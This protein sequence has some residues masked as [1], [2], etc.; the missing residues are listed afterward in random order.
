MQD[1]YFSDEELVAYLDGEEDFAPVK[2]IEAALATDSALRTRIEALEFDTSALKAGFEDIRPDAITLPRPAATAAPA[3]RPRHGLWASITAGASAAALALGFMLGSS[4]STA[5]ASWAEYVAAYQ[6]LYS[7]ST[8]AHISA[9]PEAQQVELNRVAASIGKDIDVGQLTLFP[10]VQ[11]TR[12]QILSFQGQAL[13]QL[14][15]LTS[16]GEPLALCVIRSDG[17]ADAALQTLRMEGL[18][19]ALWSQNGYRYILIGGKD[20]ALIERMS[21]SFMAMAI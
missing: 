6:A 12:S 15:F 14:A 4:A 3:A 10:D 21:S 17:E 16:T 11:Y 8:L 5:P 9:T 19:T 13:I 2:E 20:D 1:R 18:S 7:N